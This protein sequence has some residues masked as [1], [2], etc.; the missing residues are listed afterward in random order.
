ML[1]R[2]LRILLLEDNGN[3]A[4]LV[5]VALGGA[6]V[7]NVTERVDTENA[8]VAALHDFAPDIILS[9]HSLAQFDAFAALRAVRLHRPATP[10]I[11]VTGSGSEEAAVQCLKAGADDYIVKQRL[12]LLPGAVRTAVTARVPLEKLTRRQREVLRLLAQGHPT[13]DIAKRLKLSVKTVETHRAELMKRLDIHDVA[14]LVRFAVRVH[15]VAA[16]E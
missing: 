2:P 15:L 6:G 13:R 4:E 14:G 8:F 16:E 7:G 11:V 10:L 9:D 5:S 3:D 1:D 12:S